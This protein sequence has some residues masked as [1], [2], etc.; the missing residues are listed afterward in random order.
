MAGLKVHIGE[1][2]A[3]MGGR[4]VSAWRRASAGERVDDRHLTFASL[5]DAARVLTPKRLALLR[6]VHQ[7]GAAPSVRA[8]AG[9]LGRDY[10]NVHRDVA[11]LVEAGLMDRDDAGA[12][13]AGYD[14]ISVAMELAL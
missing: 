9:S 8:L 11:A 14:R 10:K 2:A 12:L 3:E 6:A 13:R 7:Q 5:E 4:F 1:G